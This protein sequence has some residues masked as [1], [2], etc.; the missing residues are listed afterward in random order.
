MNSYTEMKERHQ[1]EVN[2]L[3]LVFAFSNEQFVTAMA[4]LGLTPED[5]DKVYKLGGISGGG[6]HRR[7]DSVL[8]L[9]T[10]DRHD[11]EREEA[12]NGDKTGDGY[13]YEMFRYELANH[14]YG[15]TFDLSDT[16]NALGYSDEDIENNPALK[17]GLL[18]AAKEIR[19]EEK[20]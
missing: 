17:H 4:I 12:I 10:F 15:Y 19:E 11:K 2:A 20:S 13:I 3:P 8:I 6:F 1:R 5:T 7:E 14:E 9:G 18:K 16:L